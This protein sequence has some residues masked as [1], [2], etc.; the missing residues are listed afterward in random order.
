[1]TYCIGLDV[2]T[3]ACRSGIPLTSLLNPE[4]VTHFLVCVGGIIPHFQC[5]VRYN[6]EI[7]VVNP[8][9]VYLIVWVQVVLL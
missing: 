9:S 2:N 3:A 6:V 4:V 7:E 1:M 5:Q 8:N